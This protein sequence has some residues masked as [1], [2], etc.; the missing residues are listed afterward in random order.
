LVAAPEKRKG[1]RVA[2][3]CGRLVLQER[4]FVALFAACRPFAGRVT[5]FAGLMGKILA[6]TLDFPAGSRGVTL[7]AILEQFLVRL[8]VELYPSFQ[9]DHVGGKGAAGEGSK[10]N[11][12]DDSCFH[13]TFSLFVVPVMEFLC[14]KEIHIAC[15]TACMMQHA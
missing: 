12:G 15:Q 7:G 8:V 13:G 3:F 5:P 2:A 6:E 1:G 10:G 11:Q 9:L 4:L 14:G